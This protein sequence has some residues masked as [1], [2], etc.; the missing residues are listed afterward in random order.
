MATSRERASTRYP[1]WGRAMLDANS[2]G[3]IYRGKITSFIET[4]RQVEGAAEIL[5]ISQSLQV[6]NFTGEKHILQS[7]VQ[8]PFLK[9]QWQ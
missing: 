5:E 7:R 6:P 3:A 4:D 9:R 8:Q 2:T 1:N